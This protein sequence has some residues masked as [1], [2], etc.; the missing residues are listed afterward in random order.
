M[1]VHLAVAGDVFSGVLFCAVFFF[2]VSW[3]GSGTELIQF[4]RI[5]PTYSCILYIISRMV[6][7]K[8]VYLHWEM[9]FNL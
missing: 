4:L 8:A 3:M 6:T 2:S 5:F 7:P 1:A 9:C